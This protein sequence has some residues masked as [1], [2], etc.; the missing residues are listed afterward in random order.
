MLFANKKEEV[1]DIQLTPHGRY[2]L[3]IGKLKPVYYSF[4]DSNILYDARYASGVTSE[5]EKDV[6]KRIQDNTPQLRTLPLRSSREASVKSLYET[7]LQIFN[8]AQATRIKTLAMVEQEREEKHYLLTHPL[9]TSKISGD[10]AVKWSVKVLNGEITGSAPYLTSSYQTLEIPQIDIDIEYEIA[11]FNTG[12]EST[13]EFESD[14][15]LN[16]KLFLDGTYVSIDPD[17]LLLDIVEENT[18]YEVDNFEIEVFVIKDESR[19]GQGAGL[20]GSTSTK[21]KE[22]SALAFEKPVSLIQNNILLDEDD[23]SP[24]AR[25]PIN[26]N[27]VKYYFDVNVDREIDDLDICNSISTLESKN[28]YVDWRLECPDDGDTNLIDIYDTETTVCSDDAA[29]TTTEEET[30]Y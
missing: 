15:V 27:F 21:I 23:V 18:E 11:I 1:L 25:I 2:L 29:S 28:L 20:S 24:S 10:E 19:A 30:P 4:H 13:I 26:K 9:G 3:A 16:S 5:E 22:L 8:L 7:P 14:P 6:E 12:S 17:H